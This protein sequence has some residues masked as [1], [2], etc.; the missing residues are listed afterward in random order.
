ML[1]KEISH[2]VGQQTGLR[3]LQDPARGAI[4][5]VSFHG[6]G[7]LLGLHAEDTGTYES[8]LEPD[9]SIRGRG[10][11]I[12]M[13]ERGEMASWEATGVGTR[14]D[15]GATSFRGALYYRSQSPTFSEL[16]GRC[17]VYEYDV[18]AGG[19]TDAHLYLWE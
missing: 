3:V 9:G 15:D 2:E 7:T 13:G 12:T 8:W 1:G 16:N 17:C 4:M 18:D 14:R 10:Q 5:E 11:G 6:E 19:K